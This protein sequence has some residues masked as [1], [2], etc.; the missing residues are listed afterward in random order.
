MTDSA[1][2]GYL[3]SFPAGAAESEAATAV[4]EQPQT[5]AVTRSRP[6]VVTGA[7]GLV[8]THL[9][10][11]LVEAGWQLRAIVRDQRKAALRIGHLPVDIRAGDIRDSEF[12]G[13]ALSDAGALVHLAAIAIEKRGESYDAINTDATGVILSAARSAG[14]E[15]LVY[16]S[17]NGASSASRYRFLRSKGLAE[18]MVT[19]GSTKWTVIRPSVIFGP[20]DEFVNVLA[21]LVR[22]TPFIFPLPGGGVAR[23]QPISVEDVALAVTKSLDDDATLGRTLTIGGSTPLT[24]R[25][26]TERILVAMKASRM[27]VSVPVRALRPVIALAERILPRPPV[28]TGLLDLLEMDNV[29]PENHLTTVLGIT[30]IPFAPEELLYLRQ[31]TAFSALRSLFRSS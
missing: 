2:G 1:A 4:A 26:M 28:T 12:M 10:R 30:P 25:Q 20:E 7:S 23:F 14:V 18:E 5:S 29:V 11:Q 27:L 13:S 16:M 22:L 24:L 19:S 8:G 9:C 15:R 3:T 31:I 17:Q 6:V 21:R